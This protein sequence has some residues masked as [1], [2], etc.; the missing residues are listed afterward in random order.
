MVVPTLEKLQ[1]TLLSRALFGLSVQNIT[2][3][4]CMHENIKFSCAPCTVIRNAKSTEEIC[5]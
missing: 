5:S 1:K 2:F 4:N 3:G